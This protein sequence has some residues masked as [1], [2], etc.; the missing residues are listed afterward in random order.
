MKR[1]TYNGQADLTE[2]QA[3]VT[4]R[5]RVMGP[6]TNLHPGDVAH[7]IYS[8]SR[9]SDLDDVVPVWQDGAGI[10]GF[11]IVWPKD[12]AFD[13]VTR[14]G[15]TETDRITIIEGITALAERD[16]GVET[17]VIGDDASFISILSG[18][19]FHDKSAEYVFTQ[20]S[21]DT[22]VTIPPHDFI[23]RSARDDDA[24]Q[25]AA[26]HSAAFG[27]SWAW[28][29]YAKR[30]RQP[31]YNAEDELVAVDDDGTFMGFTNTWYDDVNKVGYFEP[32]GVHR[33]FHR[34]GIGTVLI[35]KGMS[36]MQSRGMATATVWHAR[37]EERV[38]R[39]YGS[40]GFDV[41][42]TV[43]RWERTTL[44]G[45]IPVIR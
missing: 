23:V 5:T 17:D 3:M 4:E 33:D 25:L 19:G 30:M 12:R 11:G 22:P 44:D 20:R 39:F 28:D 9:T 10:A 15:L 18:L 37:S 8:G 13:V 43:M 14:V 45:D 6:C 21:L 16:G 7:R 40:I 42:S 32:V 38:V 34:R 1:R 31:G 2:M 36:S 41:F 26:V 35:H 27:S 24:G 29:E